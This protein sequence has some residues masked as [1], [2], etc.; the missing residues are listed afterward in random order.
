MGRV[1]VVSKS[2]QFELVG[3]EGNF[4][5]ENIWIGGD[6]QSNTDSANGRR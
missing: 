5:G 1:V 4:L 3:K 2:A 6:G